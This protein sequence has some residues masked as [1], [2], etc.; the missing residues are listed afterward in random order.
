M[1]FSPAPGL[2]YIRVHLTVD[3]DRRLVGVEFVGGLVGGLVG[4][5]VGGW[6]VVVVVVFVGF[7]RTD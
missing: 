4:G 3:L 7:A 6:V 2:G 5:W 1:A